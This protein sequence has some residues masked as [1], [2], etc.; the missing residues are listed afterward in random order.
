MRDVAVLIIAIAALSVIA[1]PH[2]F[3]PLRT[4]PMPQVNIP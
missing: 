1:R 2:V 4:A 3:V